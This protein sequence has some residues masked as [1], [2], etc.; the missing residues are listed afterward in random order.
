VLE[1]HRRLDV[2]IYGSKKNA[3]L[4][5]DKYETQ[6]AEFERKKAIMLHRRE[7]H[8]GRSG[9]Y[10]LDCGPQ[11]KVCTEFYNCTDWLFLD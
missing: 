9:G 4:S 10:N 6:K 1:I 5:Q 2:I 3:T 7:V 8:P 11:L